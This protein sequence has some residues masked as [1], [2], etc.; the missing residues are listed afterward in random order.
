MRRRILAA[1]TLAL[2]AGGSTQA[3]AFLGSVA[4]A[5]EAQ[6]LGN[7]PVSASEILEQL[8]RAE[9]PAATAP[10]SHAA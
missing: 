9:P 6:Q 5:I 10:L 8:Y 2:A 3:A 4:A 7:I 1:A